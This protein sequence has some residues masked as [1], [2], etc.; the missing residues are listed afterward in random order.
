MPREESK[1]ERVRA[2][3]LA[4]PD[5][6]R[7]KI[8]EA[9]GVSLQTVYNV[10][11]DR[12]LRQ[13]HGRRLPEPRFTRSRPVKSGPEEAAGTTGG[14]AVPPVAGVRL[15]VVKK[16][17]GR[18]KEAAPRE[19]PAEEPGEARAKCGACGFVVVGKPPSRC[20]KCGGA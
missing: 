1:S 6:P 11:Y 8:A 3:L 13:K 14:A 20:P 5:M 17:T 16:P 10:D 4:H 19:P 7:A 15:V 18:A 9:C 12:R 2:Y